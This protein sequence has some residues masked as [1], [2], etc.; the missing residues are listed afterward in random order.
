M[1]LRALAEWPIQMERS[2]LIGDRDTDLEAARRVNL[3]GYKFDGGDLH[4]LTEAIL[5]M[6]Q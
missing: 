4:K 3:P 5:A 6:R 2:F 1:I